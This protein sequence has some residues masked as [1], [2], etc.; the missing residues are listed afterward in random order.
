M[1][2]TNEGLTHQQVS[3]FTLHFAGSEALARGVVSRYVAAQRKVRV[4]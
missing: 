4:P 3:D 1:S 2:A